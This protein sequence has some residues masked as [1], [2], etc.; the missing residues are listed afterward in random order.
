MIVLTDSVYGGVNV[1]AKATWIVS[2]NNMTGGVDVHGTKQ[3]VI[4]IDNTNGVE[5]HGIKQ[6]WWFY[7]ENQS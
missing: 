7:C 2:T 5:A 6:F 1:H 4:S 3:W